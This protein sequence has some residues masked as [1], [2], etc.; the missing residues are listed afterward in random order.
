MEVKLIDRGEE[1]EVILIGR[2]DS[3]SSAAAEELFMQL[4]D[5]FTNI[6]LDMKELSFISS[7]GLRILKKLY[8]K[9]SKKG[10]RLTAVNMGSYLVEVFEVTGFATILDIR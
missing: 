8:V 2:L 1:G 10:G 3:N 5:R 9:L 7:A 4:A 6:K